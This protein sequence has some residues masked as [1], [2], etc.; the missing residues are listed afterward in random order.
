MITAKASGKLYIAGE[1]AVVEKGYPAIISSVDKFVTVSVEASES[2]GT[3]NSNRFTDNMIHWNRENGKFQIDTRDNQLEFIIAAINCVE[4]YALQLGKKLSY[5]NINIESELDSD[6]GRKYGLGSSAAVSVATVRALSKFYKL[7]LNNKT[8]YKL[9]ALSHLSVQGNGS[10]GDVA[11]STYGGIIYY[12]SPDRNWIINSLKKEPLFTIVH[13]EWPNLSI[14]PLDMPNN[15]KLLIG[16]TGSPASTSILVE[17]ISYSKAQKLKLYE[18]FLK[19][20][21][22][23]LERM[24]E[25]FLNADLPAIQAQISKNREL[26][27]SLSK[28]TNVVIETEKLTEMCNVVENIGQAAKSSGAGGGDCGIAIVPDN[29]EIIDNILTAW[30]EIDVIDLKLNI[31]DRS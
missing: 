20:S 29:N 11:A 27:T 15:S 19:D 4:E 2:E 25:G 6:N 28:I 16:W 30:K 3:L 7:D 5:F 12:T 18:K 24:Q 21:K 14:E 13:Q 9:A 22:I 10:L 23:C 26:L 1:Y 31:T 17:Q 8:I